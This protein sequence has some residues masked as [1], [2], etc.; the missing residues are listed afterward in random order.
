[1]VSKNIYGGRMGGFQIDI[2][3]K[4]IWLSNYWDNTKI[5]IYIYQL[6]F[7]RSL[8]NIAER[9]FKDAYKKEK[10]EDVY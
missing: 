9:K 3:D 7:I 6:D 8:L 1:M 2:E 10:E 5:R 4:T